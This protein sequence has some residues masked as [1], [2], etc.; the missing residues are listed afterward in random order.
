MFEDDAVLWEAA[1]R[2]AIMNRAAGV[3][4]EQVGSDRWSMPGEGRQST[5]LVTR[6]PDE[7]FTCVCSTWKK[8]RRPCCHV[9]RVCLE[10]ELE[11][12]I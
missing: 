8:R 9:A 5:Y 11:P 10:Y 6:G 1:T 4:V 12:R 7:R 2:R 3:E